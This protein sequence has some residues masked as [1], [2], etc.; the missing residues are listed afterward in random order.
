MQPSAEDAGFLSD[1]LRMALSARGFVEDMSFEAYRVSSLHQNAVQYS[2]VIIGEAAGRIS[3]PFRAAHPEIAWRLIVDQRNIL[4][5][6]FSQIQHYRI[7]LVLQD[8]L[9]QLI[10]QLRPLLPE[11]S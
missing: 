8:D 7:W 1:M 10:T 4:V 5:H 3:T 2:L 6:G 11:E 9:P